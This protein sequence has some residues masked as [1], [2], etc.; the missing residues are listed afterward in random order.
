V[1]KRHKYFPTKDIRVA[2]ENV[3]INSMSVAIEEINIKTSMKY[4]FT[5]T[6]ETKMAKLLTSDPGDE[7]ENPV[8]HALLEGRENG[9][10]TLEKV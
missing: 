6:G 7:A 9:T 4:H 2:N 3:K 5:S 1:G 10:T 8:T